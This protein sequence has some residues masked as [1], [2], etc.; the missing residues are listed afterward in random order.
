MFFNITKLQVR[1]NHTHMPSNK[2]HMLWE[3]E[4]SVATG[5]RNKIVFAASDKIYLWTV[6]DSNQ[7]EELQQQRTHSQQKEM[8]RSRHLAKGHA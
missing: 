4:R 7:R 6:N 2:S 8:L 3:N 5:I 1:T